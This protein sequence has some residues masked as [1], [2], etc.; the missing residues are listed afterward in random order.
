MPGN[1]L[2]DVTDPR[3]F[4]GAN[5]DVVRFIRVANPFAHSDVGSV[6][7]EL[8]KKIPGAHHYCPSYKS[9]AYVVLHTDAR[10]IFAIAY[11]QRGLAVRLPLVAHGEAIADGGVPTSEIGA[12]WMGFA[13]WGGKGQPDWNERLRQWC[14]RAFD[15]AST[16]EP[17]T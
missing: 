15:E 10:R 12:E 2:I 6:L 5:E 1:F 16:G 13:P 9:C 3:F 7:I 14:R 11:G 8:G 4:T 17:S